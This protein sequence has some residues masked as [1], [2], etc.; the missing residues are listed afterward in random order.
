MR[1]GTPA[2]RLRD[3]ATR[4]RG[5]WQPHPKVAA[6]VSEARSPGRRAQF[7]RFALHYVE[8][9]VAMC[10]GFAIGDAIFFGL[11][12]LVGYSRP[13]SELPV[14]SVLVVTVSMTVP[15]T[16]WMLYRGMAWRVV[17]EMSAAMPVLAAALLCLSWIGAIPM[18]AMA[19][20][21]H[22]L[23]MLAMLVPM[24]LR[25]DFYTG[26]ANHLT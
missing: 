7:V 26:C 13:F 25:L 22:G 5:D 15:M 2:R 1:S 17:A 9:C 8:M 12:G 14:L 4:W 20:A 16:G 19:P 10:V 18:S 3:H 11:A 6:A 21:E 23:M 24:L